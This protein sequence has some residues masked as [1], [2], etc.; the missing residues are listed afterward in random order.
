MRWR[1]INGMNNRLERLWKKYFPHAVSRVLIGTLQKSGIFE[2]LFDFHRF[3]RD[4]YRSATGLGLRVA[5]YARSKGRIGWR[6]LIID[7]VAFS[8]RHH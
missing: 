8:N 7:P 5:H 4:L 2:S 3:A 6:I 1:L